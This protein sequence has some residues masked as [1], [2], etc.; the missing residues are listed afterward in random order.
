MKEAT[1]IR[2]NI[3]KWRQT[4]GLATKT[5]AASPDEL[6]DAYV[7][8]TSDLSFAQTHYP[9][10]RITEYLNALASALH[11]GI[12]RYKRERWSRL[13]TFW[14][15]E[16][17]L[18]MWE[19]RRLLLSSLAIFLLSALVGVVSQ[20]LDADFARFVLGDGYVEM[21]LDN[22]QRGE[23]MAVYDSERGSLMFVGITTNNIY[24]AFLTF[25]LGALT[26]LGTGWVLF[27]NGLMLG[28]FQTFFWQ[29]G[30]LW[31]SVLAIWL[32][33]TLE[34]S[35]IIVAGAAGLAM[36]NGLL[37]PGT[38]SRLRSFRMGALRGVRIV[39]GVLPLFVVAGF[40]ES[41]F[42]R[43]V[44]WPDAVRLGIILTS[45]AVVVGYY[46]VLP[47]VVAKRRAGQMPATK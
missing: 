45:A 11:N 13:L 16:V 9:G 41:F 42:T 15:R 2:Q 46:V 5:S 20:L 7:D 3:E 8:V 22:I 10:S 35:A 30:L 21:T 24:V 1:F 34:I 28:T 36:G 31:Q 14:T 47:R 27:N 44:E 12:Y 6:A 26:S 37:F 18:V 38:Y 29:Q 39:I 17:P 23:P 19:S 33:G 40:I 43:H 25:A 32:H 4:E